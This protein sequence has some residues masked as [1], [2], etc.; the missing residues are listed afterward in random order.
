MKKTAVI[1]CLVFYVAFLSVQAVSAQ[2]ETCPPL[3]V[4][5][6]STAGPIITDTATPVAKG[7]FIVN[8]I[9]SLGITVNNFSGSWQRT[10]A[11]GDFSSFAANLK[12]TYGVF[13]ANIKL[14]YG[15]T[16]R[17]EVYMF[18]PPY[19]HNFAPNVGLYGRSTD[20]GGIGDMSL[21]LKYNLVKETD[22]LP[23]VSAVAGFGFPI[24]HYR[25]INPCRLGTDLLGSGSYAFTVGLNAQ[26]FISPFIMYANVWQT[27]KTDFSINEFRF[28][29]RDQIAANL[30]VE[31][32]FHKKFTACL[33][34]TSIWDTGRLIGHQANLAPA[35]KVT[36]TP[37][38]QYKATDKITVAGGVS[39]D[40]FGKNARANFTPIVAGYF[41]F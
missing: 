35:A 2:Q 31:W 5:C 15:V 30:A 26:K 11:G 33:E 41:T 8:P 36:L 16:E 40:L 32:P 24:G 22:R 3:A 4:T 19:V 27:M 12:L 28:Y 37:E 39:V 10:S 25:R 9:L 18:I 34:L 23:S 38:L 17:L 14:I 1:C 13:A 6:P 7:Q 21:F 29:P 20:F